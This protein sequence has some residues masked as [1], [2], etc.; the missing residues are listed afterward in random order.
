MP[1]RPPR[2]RPCHTPC[3]YARRSGC[4]YTSFDQGHA[5]IFLL[6]LSIQPAMLPT[7]MLRNYSMRASLTRSCFHHRTD[8]LGNLF[9]IMSLLNLLFLLVLFWI[10]IMAILPATMLGYYSMSASLMPSDFFYHCFD[11]LE[12][13]FL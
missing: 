5:L 6:V 8:L 13:C 7:S 11:L 10:I 4:L 1:T 9:L 3:S 12:A 2:G